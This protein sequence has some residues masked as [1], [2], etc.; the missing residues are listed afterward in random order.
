MIKETR[1]KK[2]DKEE[3]KKSLGSETDALRAQI[4]QQNQVLTEKEALLKSVKEEND[5]VKGEIQAAE[6]KL[7]LTKEQIRER[8]NH[9]NDLEK[10]L[11][12]QN[13]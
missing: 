9:K 3:Q 2:M 8:E 10:T 4:Q 13:Q 1:E 11:A 7:Q 6:A 5:K 12:E